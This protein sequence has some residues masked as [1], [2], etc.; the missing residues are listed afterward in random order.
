MTP[1]MNTVS[2]NI[3]ND[4]VPISMFDHGMARQIFSEV[5]KS[6]AKV[7]TEDDNAEC[8]LLSPEA[9]SQLIDDIE[10]SRLLAIATERMSHYNPDT[11]ISQEEI[12]KEF[13]FTPEMLENLDEV[14]LE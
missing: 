8:V 2:A 1:A 9:Y 5:R 11:L 14:E 4:T 13:G 3:S 7:V 6:G 10:D 12:D